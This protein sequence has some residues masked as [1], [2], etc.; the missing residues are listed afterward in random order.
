MLYHFP[1]RTS[2]QQASKDMAAETLTSKAPSP[3]NFTLATADPILRGSVALS[4]ITVPLSSA[5]NSAPP[6]A[7]VDNNRKL[8]TV[9]SESYC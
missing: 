6:H 2:V 7:S 9:N 3:R 1:G 5:E 4:D 8:S